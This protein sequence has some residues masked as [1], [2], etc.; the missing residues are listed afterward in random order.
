MGGRKAFVF[1]LVVVL[2]IA[3][4]TSCTCKQGGI[5]SLQ[6]GIVCLDFAFKFL[7][8]YE[9]KTLF[10]QFIEVLLF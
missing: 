10:V 6:F 2:A 3:G 1:H 7:N 5:T 4:K 8:T 9:F